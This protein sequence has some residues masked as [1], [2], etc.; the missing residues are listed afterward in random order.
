M[1]IE[2]RELRTAAEL[3]QMPALESRVWGDAQRVGRGQHARRHDQRRWHGD[4][5]V[6]RR[7]SGRLG[8]RLRDQPAR[9]A[10]LALPGR[11]PRLPA[12]AAS[13]IALKHQQREWCLANGRTPMR[14]TFDPLQLGNA[15]LNLR[16]L[17]AIGVRYHAEPVRTDGRHQ[18]RPAQRSGGGR[19]GP[20]RPTVPRARNRSRSPFRRSPPTRS[21]RPAP[22][23][24]HARVALR[25]ALVPLFADGWR[26]DRRRPRRP[27]LHASVADLWLSVG[28]SR[29]RRVRERPC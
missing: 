13:A 7:S 28:R 12:H 5:C 11:R 26:G 20:R 14:W 29:P 23:A 15:H 9:R 8:V 1:T 24:L 17:G 18:R 10:P 22:A 6:R 25:D 27:H 2:F 16:S 3:A 4:R 19:V 21:P